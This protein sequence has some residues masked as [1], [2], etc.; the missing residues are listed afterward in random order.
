[1]Q[2]LLDAVRV[3]DAVDLRTR[4]VHGVVDHVGGSVEQ[5]HRP[6]IDDLTRGIDADEV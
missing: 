5:A 1:M 4:G 6:T 3:R 2:A